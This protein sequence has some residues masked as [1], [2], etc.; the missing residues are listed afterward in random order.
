M[1]AAAVPEWAGE[2]TVRDP[3]RRASSCADLS[4]PRRRRGPDLPVERGR[5]QAPRPVSAEHGGVSRPSPLAEVSLFA[6][7]TFETDYVLVKEIQAK[8]AI[9]ALTLAGNTLVEN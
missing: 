2:T 9:E 4:C 3:R 7:A 6:L 8:Q 1:P 5:I